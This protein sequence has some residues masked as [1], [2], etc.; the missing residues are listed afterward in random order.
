MSQLSLFVR[1]SPLF[2]LVAACGGEPNDAGAGGNFKPGT[3]Q[4]AAQVDGGSPAPADLGQ[5]GNG[6]DVGGSLS[7][8]A[9][10]QK[11]DGNYGGAAF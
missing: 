6:G 8:A 2:L 3:P 11:D 10:Q 4:V 9:V 1:L 7:A 5:G